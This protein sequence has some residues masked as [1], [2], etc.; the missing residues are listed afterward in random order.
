MSRYEFS[1]TVLQAL[2]TWLCRTRLIETGPRMRQNLNIATAGL[3]ELDNIAVEWYIPGEKEIAAVNFLL[4]RYLAP[5]LNDLSLFSSGELSLDNETLQR[6][7]KLVL[8]IVNAISEMI[9]P[10]KSGEY[11]SVLSSHQCGEQNKTRIGI[12]CQ[13]PSGGLSILQADLR[14]T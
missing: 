7:L 6:T 4:Q 9:E 14:T 1:H 2:L 5:I 13:H 12:T 3:L 8:K 10:V 11:K